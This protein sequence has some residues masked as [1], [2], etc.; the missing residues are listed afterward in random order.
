VSSHVTF[1][2]EGRRVEG[3]P[4][5][6]VGAALYAAGTTT[7]GW[8]SKYRRPRGLRCMRGA[9]PC[10]TVAIDGQPQPAC[11]IPL[12]GGERVH[13]LRPRWGRLPLDRLSALAPAGFYYERFRRSPRLWG[14]AERVLAT[15]AGA[16]PTSALPGVGDLV[17]RDVDVLVVGGGSRG[18]VRATALAGAGASVLLVEREH[19]PGGRL[20]DRPGGG[21][22]A[23]RLV[24]D[25]LV[26]GVEV[27][28]G[29]T[30]VG[31]FDE[32]QVAVAMSDRLLVVTA[33]RIELA[34]G[35][36]DI[37]QPL[38]DG[39]RP[40]VL[41]AGGAARLIVR[42]GVLPGRTAVVASAA[43]AAFEVVELLVAR[44]V[45]V[46]ARCAPDEMVAV[47]GSHRVRGVTVRR[48]G[49]TVRVA[50][51]CLVLD[52]GRRPADELELQRRLAPPAAGAHGAG[53]L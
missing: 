15:L 9:C 29:A 45:D 27:L 46:V 26:E 36:L 53:D 23:A 32:G 5:Q 22:R 17:E 8:S 3:R 28:V 4:G 31:V 47:H 19:S 34:T 1:E 24:H 38:P 6:S 7:L 11:M 25:A 18:L 40:G 10:C 20:L 39:D 12:V 49:R 42:D 51:E 14:R 2:F 13:R 30:A 16:V 37:D 44:G 41:L 43:P 21:E 48:D 33:G 52:A 35:T 50:C